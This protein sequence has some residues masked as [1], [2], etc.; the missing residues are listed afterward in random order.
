MAFLYLLGSA[1]AEKAFIQNKSFKMN[2]YI[3]TSGFQ[4]PAWK[5]SFYP[6]DLPLSKMLAYYAT[7]FN[8]TEINYT[9]RSFPSAKT[10]ERWSV[11]VPAD[12]RYSLKAPQ[13][14]THYAK[15]RDC[16]AILRDFQAAV[17]PLGPK[18]GP[19]LFQLPATFK[20]DAGLLDA[21]LANLPQG[22]RA[23]FE[24]RDASWFDDAVYEALR[25]HG[26]ALCWADSEELSTPAV[27]TA[28]W[29]YL[30]LRRDDYT[31]ADLQRWAALASR[32]KWE[33]CLTAFKHEDTGRGPKFAAAFQKA[34]AR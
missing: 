29:G 5:G 1:L 22:M 8:A 2:H 10:I 26:A 14:I 3:G 15:L 6:A 34:V 16:A 17:A 18:L 21:F 7:Q 28:D 32:Q 19:V 23:A 33:T 9:F 20:K 11:S 4:Y 27:A 30:R 24:F 12:F 13:R 25:K 31:P